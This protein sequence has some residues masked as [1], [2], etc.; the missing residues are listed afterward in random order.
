MASTDRG[1]YYA[2]ELKVDGGE[3]VREWLQEAPDAGDRKEWHLVGVSD[4][5]GDGLILFWGTSRPS[6]GVCQCSG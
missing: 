4:L 3:G 5:P 1:R 6:F 2:E